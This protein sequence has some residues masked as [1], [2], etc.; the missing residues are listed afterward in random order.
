MMDVSK[1]EIQEFQEKLLAWYKANGRNFPWRKKSISNYQKVICE[2]LLQRTKAETISKFFP[3]FIKKYPSWKSI[4]ESSV[5]ELEETLKPIG[6]Y[7][8]R[9]GRLHKLAL[10]MKKRGGRIPNDYEELQTIPM[11]G[12]YIANAAMTVVHDQQYP[13]LDVNMARV[14]ERYFGPRK[15]AD[16]RHDPYLQA[17][18]YSIADTDDAKQ[19]NWAILDFAAVICQTQRPKCLKCVLSLSCTLFQD[20]L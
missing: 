13:L 5:A 11:M 17:L 2:V 8:Q 10:E 9:A 12:Q 3:A 6:L 15:L 4:T 19:M 7:R 20:K 18:A 1:E 16:I 14:L